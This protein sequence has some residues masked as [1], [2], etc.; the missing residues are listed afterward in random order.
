MSKWA[1]RWGLSTNQW[2]KSWVLGVFL[3][4]LAS[5]FCLGGRGKTLSWHDLR[6]VF[7]PGSIG[8]FA[9]MQFH[10]AL[11]RWTLGRNRLA[12]LVLKGNNI[13]GGG[14][15]KNRRFSWTTVIVRCQKWGDTVD[16]SEILLAS[17]YGEPTIIYRVLSISG[18]C[19]GFLP[20]TLTSSQPPFQKFQRCVILRRYGVIF[21]DGTLPATNSSHLKMKMVVSEFGI[22]FSSGLFSGANC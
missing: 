12:K 15:V 17:S 11:G 5:Y 4:C 9:M 10:P 13:C 3:I 22:S 7:V 6:C 18:G 1:T 16:G 14:C 8:K 21:E 2:K 20:S 19:L